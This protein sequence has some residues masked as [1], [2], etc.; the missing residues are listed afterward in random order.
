MREARP[1]VEDHV[2]EQRVP[3]EHTRSQVDDAAHDHVRCDDVQSEPRVRRGDV[4]LHRRSAQVHE[5]KEH[6][7]R[8]RRGGAGIRARA[9]DGFDVGVLDAEPVADEPGSGHE[10]P[11]ISLE[12]IKC[13]RRP[14]V[15]HAWE[16]RGALGR[17]LRHGNLLAVDRPTDLHAIEVHRLALDDAA[18]DLCRRHRDPVRLVALLRTSRL[19]GGRVHRPRAHREEQGDPS[20]GRPRPVWHHRDE[21]HDHTDKFNMDEPR[22]LSRLSGMVWWRPGRA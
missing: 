16:E 22:A 17:N 2:I 14:R 3:P 15:R 13:Q 6:D 21:Y 12:Q 19:G 1:V 4:V 10:S 5:L 11:Q 20:N 18:Q 8:V 9:Q 7:G